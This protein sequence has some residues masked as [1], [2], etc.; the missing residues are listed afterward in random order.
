[1]R[2]LT[3][4]SHA[5]LGGQ[6]ALAVL[7]EMQLTQ[8]IYVATCRSDL[9]WNGNTYLGGRQVGVDP[10]KDQGGEVVGLSFGLSG[11]PADL[12]AVALAEPI[13]GRRAVVR[14]AIMEPEGQQIVDVIQLWTG[15]LDQMPITEDNNMATI[16]VTAEHRGIFFARAKGVMY[17]DAAQQRLY[18]G[19]KCLEFLT[20]QAAHQDVWPAAAWGRK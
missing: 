1:V 15:T 14:L 11:V 16:N 13:Q 4:P 17:S 10:I 12:I 3:A 2:A 9:E 20:A 6:Y 19:D 8:P 5:L 7:V 18:P